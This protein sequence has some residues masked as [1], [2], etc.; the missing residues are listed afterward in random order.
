MKDTN[1]GREKLYKFVINPE[2]RDPSKVAVNKN[3]ADLRMM[4]AFDK[5]EDRE[6]RREEKEYWDE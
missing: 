5:H 2:P 1:K 6:R 4:E 3:P